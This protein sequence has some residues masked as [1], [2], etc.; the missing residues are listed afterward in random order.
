MPAGGLARSCAT[1]P[2]RRA[3]RDAGCA[4][5]L[6]EIHPPNL[7][8]AGLESALRDLLAPLAVTGSRRRWTFP[9]AS[10]LTPRP[11][12]SSSARQA[13]RSGTSQ[14]HAGARSVHVSVSAATACARLEVVDDGAGFSRRI[15]STARGGACR[16]VAPGGG[17]GEPRRAPR[18][19][20][21]RRRRRH[22]VR[23]RGA[24]PVIRL[25]IAD[26]HAVVRAGLAQLA[27]DPRRGRARRRR[28]ERRGGGRAVRRRSSGRRADGHRD[29]RAGRDRGDAADQGAPARTSRSSSSRRSPTASGSCGA[30]DAGAAGYLLKDAEPEELARAIRAAAAGESRSTRRRRARSSA[31]A[32]RAQR[33][34]RALRSGARGA[35]AG[36]RRAQQQAHRAAARDQREDVKAHL[37]SVFADRRH[38][39]DAGRALG[40]AERPARE[41]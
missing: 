34:R 41:S 11:S 16:P 3:R 31:R 39:P 27:R 20:T 23:P 28:G 19:A 12:C 7:Q 24:R 30:L 6:V 15:S 32:R 35:A 10:D 18:G 25:V 38:R 4:R 26:D 17:R 29:A 14:R 21:R 40:R 36:C 37:T 5:V 1:R 8:N 2:P 33:R 9:S 22:D 13:R